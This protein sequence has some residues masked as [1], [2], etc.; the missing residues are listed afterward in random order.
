MRDRSLL[1]AGRDLLA[2]GEWDYNPRAARHLLWE[3]QMGVC[4]CGCERVLMSRYRHPLSGDHDTIDHVWPIG[5]RGPDKLGNLMLL[6]RNCNGRKGSRPPTEVQLVL[7]DIVNAKLG[8]PAPY[9][10]ALRRAA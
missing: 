1:R 6:T 10:N 9:Y 2:E 8:W 4:G 5:F 7:L 3:A